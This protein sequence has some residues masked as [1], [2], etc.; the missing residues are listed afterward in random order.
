MKDIPVMNGSGR[1]RR[2]RCRRRL[3]A[4]E[5]SR[6]A[7]DVMIRPCIANMVSIRTILALSAK[8]VDRDAVDIAG[9]QRQYNIYARKKSS[10]S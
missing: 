1:Q 8:L 6:A 7:A 3:F 10:Q 9:V 2:R 5:A 4:Y